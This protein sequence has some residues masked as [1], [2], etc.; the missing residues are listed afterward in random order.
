MLQPTRK[1]CTDFS[2]EDNLSNDTSSTS[3]CPI[4]FRVRV[5]LTRLLFFE[6]GPKVVGQKNRTKRRGQNV[7]GR[8]DHPPARTVVQYTIKCETTTK[9]YSLHKLDTLCLLHNFFVLDL[10]FYF[11]FLTWCFILF[12]S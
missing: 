8:K 5:P 12:V 3:F 9:I 4:G 2:S 11:F 7:V 1:P 10:V 6:I